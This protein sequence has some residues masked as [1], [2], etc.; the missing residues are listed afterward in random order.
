M[1]TQGHGRNWAEPKAERVEA[2]ENGIGAAEAARSVTSTVTEHTR[3]L[4]EMSLR[5][6]PI[7]GVSVV[8][9]SGLDHREMVHASDAIISQLDDLQFVLGEGPCLD[10]YRYRFPVLEPHLDGEAAAN[11]WPG[12]A[13]EAT[14][15]GAA[16]IFAFPLQ[17]GAVPFGVLEMY[18]VAPGGLDEGD[19]VTAL[20]LVDDIVR[21]V[22]HYLTDA[23]LSPSSTTAAPLFGRS[24]IP[25]ATGMVAVQLN[26]SIPEALAQLRA[27]AFVRNR[28]VQS[29]A[30][31]VVARR[32]TFAD[33]DGE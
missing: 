30:E 19:L 27:A 24:E 25:Q 12:F 6:L 11:R 7:D 10:A 14:Q 28:S 26:V 4:C 17:V 13:R 32:L 16:A 9:R 8:V 21:V 15:A 23:Q 33:L 3:G 2:T 20:L 1:T 22:L 31:D 18:R 5:V 29:I